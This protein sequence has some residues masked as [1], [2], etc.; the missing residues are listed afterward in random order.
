[1][2]FDFNIETLK[3]TY[4]CIFRFL[5]EGQH[6]NVLYTGNAF[7]PFHHLLYDNIIGFI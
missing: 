6:G 4:L 7:D 1:M 2:V 3:H 5:F